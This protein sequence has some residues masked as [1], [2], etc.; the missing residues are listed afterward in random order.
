MRVLLT[1]GSGL[2]SRQ[3]ATRLG[4]LHHEVELLS[5]TSL[6]LAR[7]TRHVRRVHQV[8]AFGRDPFAWLD[9]AIAVAAARRV[10]VLF[11]TQEQVTVLSAFHDR[12]PVRTLVPAFAALRRVQDKIAASRSLQEFGVP[13]P[14]TRVVRDERELATVQRFPVFVKRAVSTAS[15]GV[16]RVASPEGL[17]AAFG[18]LGAFD[19]EL[20]VQDQVDG[21]LAMV[22]AVADHGRLVALHANVRVREGASGG[23]SSKESLVDPRIEEHVRRLVVGLAWHGPI[24]LDAIMTRDGPVYI[25]VNPRLVEPRNALLAGVDLVG[26]ILGL[27]LGRHPEPCPAGRA[28]VRSHQVLLAELRAA[29][30]GRRAV[31]REIAQAV[32][33]AGPYA[34]SVEELTPARGDVRALLPPVLVALATLVSP[35]TWRFFAGASIDAYAVSPSGWADIVARA[36]A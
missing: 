2:T 12:V 1:E 28:G 16:R 27:A 5:S 9:A 35:G 19:R 17:R 30:Q 24:S 18:E 8:P 7:F 26:I 10:D 31:L 14:P 20:L 36:T 13:Q 23:A 22:Q 3:V 34:N 29:Q 25:D 6:C 11:P 21:P 32:R 4:E 15:T 33:H